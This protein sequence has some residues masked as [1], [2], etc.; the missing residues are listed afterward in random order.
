M[1]PSV[2]ERGNVHRHKGLESKGTPCK[3]TSKTHGVTS[4]I[5]IRFYAL[6]IPLKQRDHDKVTPFSPP[7]SKRPI[8]RFSLPFLVLIETWLDYIDIRISKIVIR[9]LTQAKIFIL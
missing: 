2:L 4:R 5:T 3:N 7:L 1:S 8:S 6:F 9:Q